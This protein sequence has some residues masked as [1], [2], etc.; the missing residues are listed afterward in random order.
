MKVT[1]L[2]HSPEPLRS[3]YVAF[4]TCYSS[5]APEEIWH[6]IESGRI[7]KED[8][9]AFIRKYSEV[10]HTSPFEQVW[11]EFAVSGISRA[12]SHQ[13]VRHRVGMSLEQQSQRYVKMKPDADSF[14]VPGSI[15]V[16]AEAAQEFEDALQRICDAYERLISLGVPAEDARYILPNAAKTNIKLTINLAALMHMCDIRLCTRA[17]WEFRRLAALM[18]AEVMKVE[19]VLGSMLGIK[20]MPSRKGYCDETLDAYQ[21]CPLSRVRPHKSDIIGS[22]RP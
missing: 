1:L 18:R 15:A 13:L 10:G 12:L 4:R 5:K 17:Q 16:N 20:C 22:Q 2:A 19:P 9:A 6:E 14:V 21:A 11:F 8:M 3:V 7:S